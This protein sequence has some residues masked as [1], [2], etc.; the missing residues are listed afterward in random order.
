MA[1]YVTIMDI[2]RELGISKSTV[3]R[4]L[5]GDTGNVKA[6]TLKKILETAGRMGYHRNELAVNFRQQSTHNIGIIIP[7]I[8]TTFYMTFINDAQAI[9]RKQG[10]KVM[11]AIS[12]E[13]PDQDS[14]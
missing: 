3:S 7:E 14:R 12:N 10:Y 9:L 6:E 11:I 4:A 13:N 8:V 2:A 1:K 5:S